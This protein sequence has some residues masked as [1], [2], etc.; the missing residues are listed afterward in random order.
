MPDLSTLTTEA[1]RGWQQRI[2]T[3]LEALEAIVEVSAGHADPQ[4]SREYQQLNAQWDA[5]EAE[6]T[7]R[8]APIAAIAEEGKPGYG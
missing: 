8:A 4:W 7:R 3:R 5:I 6:W 2:E 1:L